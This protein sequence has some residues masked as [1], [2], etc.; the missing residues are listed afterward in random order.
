VIAAANVSIRHK[1]Q[2]MKK[3]E[4]VQA[5]RQWWVWVTLSLLL[6]FSI[7]ALIQ[8]IFLGQEVGNSPMPNWL[9]ILMVLL[10][11]LFIVT[12]ARL[13]LYLKVDEE[14]IEV[15]FGLLGKEKHSWKEIRQAQIRKA[16]IS[17]FGRR[18]H[19]KL[20][21]VYRAQG[22][23]VLAVKLKAGDQFAVSTKRARELKLLLSKLKK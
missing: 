5:F 23:E 12:L 8:Q 6:I 7:Y 3:I 11:A 10:I 17:G 2:R 16:G 13:Q 4:E 22:K 21:T 9:L 18:Q 19:P 15:D 14:G 1:T 20:G